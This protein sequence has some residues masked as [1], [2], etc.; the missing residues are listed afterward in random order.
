[1]DQKLLIVLDSLNQG[2]AERQ[3][4]NLIRKLKEQYH[5]CVLTLRS[6]N[7]PVAA[8]LDELEVAYLSAGIPTYW[9]G[10]GT[11]LRNLWRM[12]WAIRKSRAD[13][14]LPYT[15]YPNLYCN[16]VWKF[17]QAKG[18]LWNQR[19]EGRGFSGGKIERWGLKQ[20]SIFLSN[21]LEGK[22]Y[23][24]KK[25][26]ID[27][28]K[29][30][31]V[32]N[33]IFVETPVYDRSHFEKQFPALKGKL[34][35]TM[36]ANLHPYKKQ[37]TLIKLW[38]QIPYEVRKGYLLLLAGKPMGTEQ[39]LHELA[40][41][42]GIEKEVIQ[43]GEVGAISSLISAT[44]LGVHFSE[45]EGVPNA[46]LEMM[47]AAKPVIASNIRGCQEALGET[48]PYLF[49]ETQENACLKAF[50]SLLTS[51]SNREHIGERNK[52]RVTS[53]FSIEGM[54]SQTQSLLN[55]IG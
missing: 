48:Y 1:M 24:S 28:D 10:Y 50:H 25:Q 47:F 31:L 3:A 44:T 21:S 22:H 12:Y 55:S 33:G 14:I 23:L 16:S 20:S 39:E 8:Q 7:G 40:L 51:P 26:G 32:H 30:H 18:C 38:A 45:K 36:I 42:L 53:N 35:V 15:F 43:L 9:G 29:I 5:I 34:W 49:D 41:A 6:A 27:A 19:D 11:L 4:I 17:T 13:I 46:V 52:I 54:V 2:G 37:E